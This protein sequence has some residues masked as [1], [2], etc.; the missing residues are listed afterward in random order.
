[1]RKIIKTI[2]LP[3]MVVILTVSGLLFVNIT[4][5]K[6]NISSVPT[7]FSETEYFTEIK[8]IVSLEPILEWVPVQYH[9]SLEE[10]IDKVES[11]EAINE[12]IEKQVSNTISDVVY[13]TYSFDQE[14]II[15]DLMLVID[16]YVDEAES[17]TNQEIPIEKVK[18]AFE[19][20]ISGYNL[21]TKYELV[22]TKVQN[23][24]GDE[25]LATMKHALTF[26]NN[27]DLFQ[28]IS[29]VIFIVSLIGLLLIRA[30]S[31]LPLSLVGI[32]L[33]MI[34]KMIILTI[35]SKVMNH[36]GGLNLN[37]EL[38]LGVFAHAYILLG[39]LF[40]TGLVVR[41]IKN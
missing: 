41:V 37:L 33:L 25:H 26:I 19:A 21:K 18:T 23:N 5:I 4:T 15:N 36:F 24:I 34:N 17:I 11:D 3:I 35:T 38:E 16:D 8:E 9:E 12:I 14:A 7:I 39:M 20:R 32:V 6:E 31:L 13:G 40:V 28:K 1:M 27:I 2:I 29:L 22:I 10:V 30:S